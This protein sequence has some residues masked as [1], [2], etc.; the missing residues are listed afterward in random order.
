MGKTKFDEILGSLIVK[1]PGKLTLV[2]V[3]DK[4]KAVITV[5]VNNEFNKIEED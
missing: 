5:S 1:P 3:E 4:R 2:P